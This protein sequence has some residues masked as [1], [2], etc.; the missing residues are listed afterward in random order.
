MNLQTI[1]KHPCLSF[2]R[3][4]RVIRPLRYHSRCRAARPLAP[5]IR[6]HG[7]VTA[8]CRPRLRPMAIRRLLRG[9]IRP[10]R[11]PPFTK[12]AVLFAAGEGLTCPHPRIFH[13][14]VV[15][16]RLLFALSSPPQRSQ[17]RKRCKFGVKTCKLRQNTPTGA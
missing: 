9:D 6:G 16:Y 1:K 8:R 2:K 13:N 4:R 3:Q 5:T 7:Q 17:S 10:R 14:A 11:V 15:I 12:P